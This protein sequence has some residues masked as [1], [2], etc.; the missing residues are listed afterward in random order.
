V[1]LPTQAGP[2]IRIPAP[3]QKPVGLGDMLK[4][5]TRR[6]GFDP[7]GGCERRAITLNRWVTFAPYHGIKR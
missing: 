1:K 2:I 3:V 6:F 4:G 7:C 5:V